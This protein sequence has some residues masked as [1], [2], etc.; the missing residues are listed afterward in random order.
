MDSFICFQN[1]SDF[2]E[3]PESLCV[4]V[5]LGVALLKCRRTMGLFFL[6]LEICDFKFETLFSRLRRGFFYFLGSKIEISFGI[7]T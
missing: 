2:L 7:R 5:D 3:E 1:G 6:P 4:E